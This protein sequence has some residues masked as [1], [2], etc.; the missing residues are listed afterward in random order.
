MCWIPHDHGLILACG[1][2]YGVI[3]LLTYT[4]KGQWDVKINNAHPTDCNAV[5]WDPAVVPGSFIDQH[6]GRNPITARSFHQVAVTTSLNCG[7]MGRMARG[8][9]SRNWRRTA[10]GFE[11][12]PE[13][14]P[15]AFPPT[16][17]PA[18]LRM[19]TCSS[20]CVVIPL[21]TSGHPSS[22]RSLVML[23]GK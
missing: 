13:P 15:L 4:K 17:L 16:S 3:P 18:A 8:R 7:M 5:S 23:C 14:P 9:R 21:E 12:W 19:V 1:S 11:M 10:T 6:Q 20:E 22:C 2:S